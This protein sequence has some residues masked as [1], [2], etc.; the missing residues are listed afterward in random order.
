MP[1]PRSSSAP[2]RQKPVA[3]ALS[4]K[5][6]PSASGSR[7]GPPAFNFSPRCSDALRRSCL[8]AGTSEDSL[9]PVPVRPNVSVS[10]TVNGS[11]TLPDTAAVSSMPG[12]PR[13]RR[14][15]IL[16]SNVA[17]LLRQTKSPTWT[18]SRRHSLKASPCGP[19]R[20]FKY[21]TTSSPSPSPSVESSSLP[22]WRISC[23][24]PPASSASLPGPARAAPRELPSKTRPAPRCKGKVAAAAERRNV[25]AAPG[26]STE[27][28]AP[29]WTPRCFGARPRTTLWWRVPSRNPAER[30]LCSAS[31][32]R[33]NTWA[34]A[35]R[36]TAGS[37]RS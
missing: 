32:P 12:R 8:A 30:P 7:G 36:C 1:A 28:T 19:G 24:S 18:R 3:A 29:A 11:S 35:A 22:R 16:D 20:T 31:W 26:A 6:S 21:T 9:W 10:V 25:T 5:H 37:S 2:T 17:S 34:R 15:R 13:T 23:T 14:R 33:A 4:S 27:A